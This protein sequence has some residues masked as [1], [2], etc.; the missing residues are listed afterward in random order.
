MAGV[1]VGRDVSV[2]C[3]WLAFGLFCLWP[4]G[5]LQGCFWPWPMRLF[6]F[7][8]ALIFFIFFSDSLA[9]VASTVFWYPR[10]LE[11]YKVSWGRERNVES[12]GGTL[13]G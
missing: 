9:Q 11:M 3:V 10:K 5:I 2:G 4:R 7:L 1:D 8:C 13:F 6:S 12:L